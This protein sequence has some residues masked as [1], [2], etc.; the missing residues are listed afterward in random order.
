MHKL[1]VRTAVQRLNATRRYT[2]KSTKQTR[3]TGL[4]VIL[5]FFVPYTGYALYVFISTNY[6]ITR[7]ERQLTNKDDLDFNNTLIKYSPH[8]VLG[9]FE[10]P[11][12]EYRIQTVYEFFFNRI[13][14]LFETNRGGVPRS[15]AQMDELMPIHKPFWEENRDN[16]EVRNEIV[17]EMKDFNSDEKVVGSEPIQ[18]LSCTWLGQSCSVV[19]LDRLK[20]LTDP[21]FSTF[22]IHP[23]VGPKRITDMPSKIE[24]VPTPDLILVSHNHPDHIDENSLKFWGDDHPQKP[25]WIVPKGLATFMISNNVSNFI[26]LSWWESCHLK[27]KGDH[28]NNVYQI[29]STPAMHWSGRSVLDAN[30]SLWCSFI[31]HKGNKPVLFHA[32]D[33]GFVHDLYKRIVKKYGSGVQLALLPCG[34]YCPE[35]HQR[36]RHINSA[37]VM[38]IMN[39][40]NAQTV[41]GIHWGT[42]LLSGEYFR[43]PK[44]KL[45]FLS[46]FNGLKERCFCPEL[47]KT[48]DFSQGS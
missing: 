21:L 17:C 40:L 32:G 42:F 7:R 25:L 22:L 43:E 45:E 9:R 48:L 10:N 28:E 38:E 1:G 20:I 15:K 26:E 13:V 35:W 19:V 33:T 31:V 46:E 41:L 29:S 36:P 24:N 14:E 27:I 12:N 8:Q 37:E 30:R 3:R 5:C 16:K 47:G 39:D 44:E 34:Q 11:F 6:E 4:K 18:H 23:T 2:A